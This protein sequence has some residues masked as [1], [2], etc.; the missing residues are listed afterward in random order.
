MGGGAIDIY[1]RGGSREPG[2]EC[3]LE[4]SKYNRTRQQCLYSLAPVESYITNP[5][6]NTVALT[7]PSE[8]TERAFPPRLPYQLLYPVQTVYTQTGST[9]SNSNIVRW[10]GLRVRPRCSRPIRAGGQTRLSGTSLRFATSGSE[11]P[12]GLNSL[13][14][15]SDSQMRSLPG[16]EVVEESRKVGVDPRATVIFLLG[17]IFKFLCSPGMAHGQCRP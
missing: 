7:G 15:P 17:E 1:M 11:R 14:D 5:Y 2:H 8:T 9:T 4:S 3:A 12:E 10:Q 16:T 6:I 13:S